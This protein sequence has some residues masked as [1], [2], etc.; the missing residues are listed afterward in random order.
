MAAWAADSGGWTVPSSWL[1]CSPTD[2]DTLGETLEGK[3][4]KEVGRG[5]K[6]GGKDRPVTTIWAL[7]CP[8]P[9]LLMAVHSYVPSSVLEARGISQLLFPDTLKPQNSWRH[10]IPLTQARDPQPHPIPKPYPEGT[11]PLGDL[12]GRVRLPRACNFYNMLCDL[13]QVPFPL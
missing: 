4:R 9:A 12:V 10:T 1:A 8:V 3:I 11:N 7:A 2:G 5:H 13:E 6:D